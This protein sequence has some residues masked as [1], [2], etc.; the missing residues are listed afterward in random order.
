MTHTNPRIDRIAYIGWRG[1]DG[2]EVLDLD[3]GPLTGLVGPT[4][5]GKSTLTMCLGYALLPDRKALD[6][7]PISEVKDA[8]KAGVDMLAESIDPRYGY[9]YVALDISTRAGGRLIAGI[10][11]EQVDGRAEFTRWLI[12]DPKGMDLHAILTQEDGDQEFT[13]TFQEWKRHCAA[14]G[15]DVI[16]RRRVGEYCQALYEAGVLPSGMSMGQDR[17]L[18][19]SLIEATFKGGVSNQVVTH[20]K[21]YLLPEATQVTDIVSG[22]QA[23]TNEV[24][25]TKNEVA[26]AEKELS[27]LQSTY[28]VGKEVVLHSLRWMAETTSTLRESLLT[29]KADVAN[30][31]ATHIQLTEDIPR[32]GR[33]IEQAELSK[34]SARRQ[35]VWE[36]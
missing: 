13:P 36:L 7:R 10:Y 21:D 15:L 20:L 2:C 26:S 18:Y 33:E 27:L 25:M 17:S 19:A 5:A 12:S 29:A 24:V 32:I 22:L 1:V 9:A 31:N 28:G 8:R 4:G 34:D 14:R 3:S 16:V 23:C 11:V 35:A 6:I 30:M